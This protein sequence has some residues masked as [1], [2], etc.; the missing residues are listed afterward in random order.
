MLQIVTIDS[1]E[2]CYAKYMTAQ[3]D[4][5]PT[6]TSS[7]VKNLIKSGIFLLIVAPSIVMGYLSYIQA[8]KTMND[9]T[10][11]RRDT[12]AYLASNNLEV[13][14]DS[15]TA[16]GSSYAS[17]V[18]FRNL[19]VEEKWDDAMRIVATAPADFPD[20]D[21]VFL[22]KPDGLLTAIST[23]DKSVVGKNFNYRDW[24]KGVSKDWQ[25]YVSEIYVRANN[26]EKVIAVAVPIKGNPGDSLQ[27][28]KL[29]GILTFQIKLD[30][31][32]EWSKQIDIGEGGFVYFTDKNGYI[33]GHP[34]H[35]A[36]ERIVDFSS[37][38]AVKKAL[39]GDSGVE[40]AYNPIDKEERLVAYKKLSKYGWAVLAQQP[41]QNAFK[42]KNEALQTMA[43]SNVAI[44]ILNCLLALFILR[45][46]AKLN[47]SKKSL[48]LSKE[49][50]DFISKATSDAIYDWNIETGSIWFSEGVQK[51]FGYKKEEIVES[52]DWWGKQIQYEDK[53][54]ID[55]EIER[56]LSSNQNMLSLDYRFKKSDGSYASVQDRAY[57]VRDNS[58][59]AV[60]YIGVMQ[61]VTDIKEYEA[62][63]KKRTEE[64]ERLSKIMVDRELKMI[65]L[66]K[67]LAKSKGTD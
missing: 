56:T 39:S 12:V 14:F 31:L 52:L 28:D 3:P 24:Y 8:E 59:K 13:K 1:Q 57:L 42:I 16:L 61:N 58:G 22:T 37:V 47:N 38:P 2:V 66:K 41:T 65:E 55:K 32:L 35:L 49:R 51:V 46:I 40:V 26:P 10:I 44:F 67:E 33:A 29:L 45:F 53:A 9:L 62:E 48:L 6:T 64:A 18:Q 23:S 4:S 15:L 30:R 36:S 20:I 27:S 50:F 17:R 5:F 7:F 25:P 19:I 11:S 21:A 63:L 43:I 34:N 54:R 60:R